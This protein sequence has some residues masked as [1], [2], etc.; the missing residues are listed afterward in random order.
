MATAPGPVVNPTWRLATLTLEKQG[1][2]A[3]R[4]TIGGDA[5]HL[6][7]TRTRS[8][9]FVG[10]SEKQSL[11][12]SPYLIKTVNSSEN[13]LIESEPK[14]PDTDPD[15]MAL[16]DNT[17]QN[18]Q[19]TESPIDIISDPMDPEAIPLLADVE[20]APAMPPRPPPIPPRLEIIVIVLGHESIRG[21]WEC[22]CEENQSLT[23][24]SPA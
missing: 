6:S 5:P 15:L 11:S 14:T 9:P 7:P 10:P 2:N 24:F 21:R 17:V 4:S 19:R 8:Q 13:T 3:R 22:E 18:L 1:N 12:S 20:N 16:D 23:V